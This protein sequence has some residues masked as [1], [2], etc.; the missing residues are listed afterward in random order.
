MASR[1]IS[2]LPAILLLSGAFCLLWLLTGHAAERQAEPAG[3]RLL[4]A[5]GPLRISSRRDG[6]TLVTASNM[7]PGMTRTARLGLSAG[8]GQSV[9]SLSADQIQSPPGPS[10]GRLIEALRIS[11]R[12]LDSGPPLNVYSGTV[13]GLNHI[14]LGRW[15]PNDLHRYEIAVRLP[16]SDANQNSL[17]GASASFRLLWT[18]SAGR[19]GLRP[20]GPRPARR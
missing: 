16:E 18:V 14:Y 20:T 19:R 13:A 5:N 10:G 6:Q 3:S 4:S 9:A 11:V 7:G 1:P 8:P 15:Q 2:A 12:R 17:Q